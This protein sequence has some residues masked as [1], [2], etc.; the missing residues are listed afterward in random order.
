MAKIV[1]MVNKTFEQLQKGDPMYIVNLY[2]EHRERLEI[3]ESKALQVIVE[4]VY[5]EGGYDIV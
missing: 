5:T 1:K 4:D 3:K 2:G